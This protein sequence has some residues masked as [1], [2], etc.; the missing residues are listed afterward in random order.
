M[1]GLIDW[2]KGNLLRAV[3]SARIE[4]IHA[5]VDLGFRLADRINTMSPLKSDP[6]LSVLRQRGTG[7]GPLR[8]TIIVVVVIVVVVNMMV[9][10]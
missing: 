6:A 1:K 9:L 8:A 2:V 10:I 4:Q 7:T 5:P 3:Y